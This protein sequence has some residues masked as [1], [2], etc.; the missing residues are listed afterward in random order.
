MKIHLNKK[1]GFALFA[2]LV[3]TGIICVF[4]GSYLAMVRAESQLTARS[5]TWN[6]AIPIAEAGIEEAFTQLKFNHTN[7]IANNGWALVNN[8]WYMR[9]RPLS[10]DAYYIVGISKSHPPQIV[11][12]GFVRAPVGTNFISR[13]IRVQTTLSMLFPNGMLA[14]RN[15]S[16]NG[17][18]IL[19]DSFDSRTEQYSTGGKYDVTKRKDN[20]SLVTNSDQADE[21]DLGNAKIYGKIASG[22]NGGYEKKPNLVVGDTALHAGNN[23]GVQPGAYTKDVNVALI[24]I[25]SP[26]VSAMTPQ[27]NPQTGYKYV[28]GT[29]DYQI[30]SPYTFDGGNILITGK[31]RVLVTENFDFKHLITLQSNATLELY[32]SAPSA[33]IGGLGI[34]NNTGIAENFVYYGLPSNTNFTFSGNGEFIGCVYAPNAEFT[35][36]GGGN[37][38]GDFAGASVTRSIVMNGHYNFHFDERLKNSGP[39]AG[40]I[41]ISWDEEAITWD[42]ILANNLTVDQL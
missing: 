41:A 23:K 29:G 8:A 3:T 31:A 38:L 14:D 18:N 16:L 25:E 12:E 28:L 22:P 5:H 9:T 24:E 1:R 20:G 4:I 26:F 21:F 30:S 32:V 27:V 33:K 17:N 13:T 7:Q 36:G 35:L 11:A 39:S 10:A 2:T 19:I 6:M 15:V 37:S 40:Y 42:T 34:Q